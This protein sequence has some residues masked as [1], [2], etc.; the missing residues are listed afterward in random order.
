MCSPPIIID[1][2]LRDGEQAAG[3]AFSREQ[4]V[5]I[6][7]ALAGVGVPEI[8]VGTPAMGTAEIRDI[9][10]IVDLR[11][12][13]RLSVWCRAHEADLEAAAQCRVSGVHFSLPVSDLH[14][15]A[16]K[17]TRAWVIDTLCMMVA[18]AR[19]RFD[20]VSVGAQDAS[21][22]EL[23]FVTEFA[24]AAASA[25]AFRVRLADT[26][27]IWH[28]SAVSAAF[29]A[30]REACPALSLEFHGH[31]DLGM[32]TANTICALQAG[33]DAA[34]VTVNG[35]GERA[36]NAALEE[37]VV[38]LHVATG[39]GSSI[40]LRGLHQLCDLVARCSRRPIPPGKAITGSN[41]FAHESGIHC[42]ALMTDP[43]T[44]Q[45]FDPCRVGRP[46]PS[47]IIGKHSGS[48]AVRQRLAALG[49]PVTAGTCRILLPRIRQC[50]TSKGT[51]LADNELLSLLD[52][53]PG[54]ISEEQTT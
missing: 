20:R 44:Y 49:R 22:S 54:G 18:R 33:A 5:Q 19:M 41:A 12:G 4:K 17:K 40:K 31:D 36:G 15:H 43:N 3:V 10:A 38:A 1:T 47:F 25:G 34:S 21:R 2:T 39:A 13:C 23:G 32:A 14:L 16:M 9:Q 52:G 8:E 53:L 7:S 37:V 28:P 24:S 50:A 48:A 30:V 46:G 51:A 11:L 35:L 27:G 45:A 6:A 26:V 29:T 42:R